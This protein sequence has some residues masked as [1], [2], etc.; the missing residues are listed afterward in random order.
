MF[1]LKRIIIAE[2]SVIPSTRL[3]TA[4]Q[5]LARLRTL[6]LKFLVEV[7]L[8]NLIHYQLNCFQIF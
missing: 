6:S 4:G 3:Y 1:S 5:T 8:I 2:S 7:S